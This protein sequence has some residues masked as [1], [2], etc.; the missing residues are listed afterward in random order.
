MV[1][2][3]A[4]ELGKFMWEVEEQCSAEEFDDWVAIF[5]IESD[6]IKKE[7]QKSRGNKGL[8]IRR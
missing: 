5:S 4:R 7:R 2:R 8:S 1:S 3:I 6:E